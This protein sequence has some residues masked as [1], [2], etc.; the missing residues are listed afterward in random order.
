MLRMK[1]IEFQGKWLNIISLKGREYF[2]P[3]LTIE[4][5]SIVKI[6]LLK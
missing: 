5:L 1:R 3:P 6:F 2:Y 4:N